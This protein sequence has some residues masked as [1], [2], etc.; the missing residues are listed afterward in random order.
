LGQQSVTAG[1]QVAATVALL[2]EMTLD[3]KVVSMDAGLLH[4][5][6]VK[7]IEEKGGPTSAP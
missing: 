2:Q 7:T 5:V 4:R 3:G 1:D 6:T